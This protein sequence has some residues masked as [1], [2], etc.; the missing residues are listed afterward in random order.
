MVELGNLLG[1]VAI[2]DFIFTRCAASCPMM[3]ARMAE[4]SSSIRSDQ[5][6]F[7]SISVDPEWD[8]PA[9]LRDYRDKVTSDDRWIFLTGSRNV[10]RDLSVEDFMLA[11]DPPEQDGKGGPIVHSSK[12]VLVDREGA[13]RGYYD[14]LSSEAMDNL[15]KDAR[16]L[17]KNK[18]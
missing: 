18:G 15:R 13:I 17:L 7:V 6:R 5:V 3:T 2:Y 12:F 11:A 16:V 9:V 4:L 14:A 10:V 1:H 8:T